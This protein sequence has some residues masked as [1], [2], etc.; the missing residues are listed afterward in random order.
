MG[1][2]TR[3]CPHMAHA[4][5]F[6]HRRLLTRGKSTNFFHQRIFGVKNSAA[7]FIDAFFRVEESAEFVHRR[8]FSRGK[9]RRIYPSTLVFRVEKSVEFVHRRLFSNGKKRRICA[10]TLLAMSLDAKN[11]AI[12]SVKRRGRVSPVWTFSS[13]TS[14]ILLYGSEPLFVVVLNFI[15]FVLFPKK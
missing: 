9:K 15:I 12:K 11:N 5:A 14:H 7:F 8:F 3:K 13:R 2:P 1:T 4:A 10:S 6:F